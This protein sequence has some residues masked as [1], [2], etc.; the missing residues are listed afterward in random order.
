MTRTPYPILAAF[1]LLSV[2]CRSTTSV[3]SLA[4]EA[5]LVIDASTDEW[6]GHMTRVEDGLASIGIQDD[7]ETVF[8][9]FVTRDRPTI[10][11]IVGTGFTV[12]LDPEGGRERRLGVRFPLGVGAGR[13][14]GP[15]G[16]APGG[17]QNAHGVQG[18]PLEVIGLDGRP[19]RYGPD[20]AQGIMV[21]ADINADYFSYELAVDRELLGPTGT[22][23]VGFETEKVDEP[24]GQE[25]GRGDRPP[26]DMNPGRGRSD[27]PGMR[28]GRGPSGG[29]GSLEIW[30]R[31]RLS[32]R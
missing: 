18:G 16:E 3:T 14:R 12:W 6:G 21:R 4:P 15:T 23:G 27:A 26:G 10:Q 7:A 11:R 9:A 29:T 30:A 17:F 8:I 31:A 20:Q 5:P 13:G 19:G 24:R 28:G 25:F 2:G 32:H 22:L 1:V